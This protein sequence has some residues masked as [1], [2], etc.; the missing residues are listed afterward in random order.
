MNKI[1]T[2]KTCTKREF[3]K[4]QGLV[5][6]LTKAKPTFEST[7]PDYEQDAK[8]IKAKEEIRPNE[9]RGRIAVL[10]ILIVLVI[11]FISVISGYMQYNLL[12]AIAMGENIAPQV[13]D[14]N[15]LRESV[16]AIIY[17]IAFII[18][19]ITFIMWFRRAYFNLH[20][21]VDHLSHSENWAA[22]AWFVPI[23]NFYRPYQIMKEMY[24]ETKIFLENNRINFNEDINTRN[25]IFW[26]TLWIVNNFVSQLIFRVYR[27]SDTLESLMSLTIAN[28]VNS[29][30]GIVLALSTIKV[31]K[32]YVKLEELML[33][34]K[35]TF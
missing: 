20:Q 22:S 31:I 21:R 3:D 27:D 24:L 18:S 4:K 9:I 17:L 6:S 28:A 30:I 33:E 13:A 15:D 10:M 16:I 14:A 7:C 5:C 1:D 11:D 23:V 2:C 35:K 32:D 12:K 29:V 8:T 34:R 26:W 25:L 19:G